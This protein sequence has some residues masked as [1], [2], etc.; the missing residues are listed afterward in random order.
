MTDEQNNLTPSEGGGGN[1]DLGQAHDH[2]HSH[3]HSHGLDHDCDD[4]LHIQSGAELNVE[5]LDPAS[6]S[7]ADALRVS[8]GVLTVVMVVMLVAFLFSGFFEVKENEV[9]IRLHFGSV[10]GEGSDRVL[11]PGIHF[12]WP[13][14]IDEVIR[15]PTKP[16][17]LALDRTFWFDVKEG[18]ELEDLEKLQA[19]RGLT[20]G[21]DG[22]LILGDRNIVHAYWSVTFNIPR[23]SAFEFAETVGDVEKAKVVVR[24]AVE[25]ALVH[26]ASVTNY[27]EFIRNANVRLAERYAQRLMREEKTGISISTIN[28]N[29]Y[30]EPIAAREAFKAV[31]SAQQ[32][33]DQAINAAK[34]EAEQLLGSAA[35]TYKEIYAAI[36]TYER[37]LEAAGGDRNATKVKEAEDVLNKAI[38]DENAG[39]E[40]ARIVL[41]ATSHRDTVVQD[42]RSEAKSFEIALENYKKTP[43]IFMSRLLAKHRAAVLGG[44]VMVFYLPRDPGKRFQLIFNPDPKIMDEL[45]RQKQDREIKGGKK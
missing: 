7:L 22:S 44:D 2:A 12:A 41:E 30:T 34:Q 29:R 43:E 28:M 39:G 31:A 16:L 23:E 38:E 33:R 14:P 11:T 10:V 15:V 35:K 5:E 45:I 27:D 13:E 42:L 8:F 6:R 21:R 24:T 20:P 37:A 4:P 32:E 1:E 19:D 40:V 17:T 36:G 18:E 25:R 9:A 26:M 3:D